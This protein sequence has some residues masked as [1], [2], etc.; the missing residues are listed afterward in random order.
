MDDLISPGQPK[1]KLSREQKVGFT[2]LLIFAIVAVGLGLVHIRNTMYQPFKL[3]SGVP[4]D[5]SSDVNGVETLAYRDTDQD[6][7]SDFEELYVYH[8]SPYLADTD[9]DGIPDGVEVKGNTNPICPQ[10]KICTSQV[11]SSDSSGVTSGT[12]SYKD[13]TFATDYDF[14][15]EARTAQQAFFSQLQNDPAAVR[16]LLVSQGMT[17]EEVNAVSDADIKTIVNKA[18]VENEKQFNAMA[19]TTALANLTNLSNLDA[20]SSSVSGTPAN[21]SATAGAVKIPAELMAILSDPQKARDLLLA[22]GLDKATISKMTDAQVIQM[23]QEALNAI[24]GTSQNQSTSNNN[25]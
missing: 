2:L 8:T 4:T 11:V 9:S 16:K 25:Q 19:T 5:V 7:L 21:L 23:M 15:Q 14:T 22:Q 24:V 12:L 1:N 6:G 17:A 13:L 18:I 10:G 20:L 3:G